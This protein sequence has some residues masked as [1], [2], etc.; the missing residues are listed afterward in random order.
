MADKSSPSALPQAGVAASDS[1]I[2]YSASHAAGI[3]LALLGMAFQWAFLHSVTYLGSVVIPDAASATGGGGWIVNSLCTFLVFLIIFLSARRFSPLIHSRTL[4]W[5]C[6][7]CLALGVLVLLLGNALFPS[8]VCT[9]AGNILTSLG[10]SPLIIMWGEIYKYLNPHREQ[11]LVTMGAAVMALA[12]YLVVILL[13]PTLYVLTFAALPFGS[14]GCLVS[15]R[16]HLEGSSDSWR[17]PEGSE[18]NRSPILLFICIAI[19]SIPYNYLLNTAQIQDAVS[20]TSMWPRVLAVAFL[21]LSVISVLE[22]FAERRGVGVI[23]GLVLLLLSAACVT[24]VLAPDRSTALVPSL[25]YSGYYLFL[26]MIYL[27]IGPLV[28]T[29]NRNSTRL[30]AEAMLFNVGGLLLGSAI[31]R[32]ESVL[33]VENAVITVLAM[34]YTILLA[35]IALLGNR[36]YSLFRINNFDK[37][38]YSFEYVLPTYP[39]PPT[40]I[41]PLASSQSDGED[42]APSTMLDAIQKQCASVSRAYGLSRREQEVLVELVRGRTIAS[43]AEDLTVSENTIKAHTKGIYRKLDVHSREEL[44]ARV[45]ESVQNS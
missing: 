3:L 29:T 21:A 44:L 38:E 19:F 26:A 39:T 30:F 4:Y 33:G 18:L 31:T 28:A 5:A 24:H 10:T 32:M 23:T 40:F 16:N 20:S 6:A 34:T 45:G 25:L 36:S 17:A 22:H 42:G 14:I 15:A 27:S 1:T 11:L 35:G 7:S 43:I 41:P 8:P 2:V 9:Y 37:E 12:L 13:P